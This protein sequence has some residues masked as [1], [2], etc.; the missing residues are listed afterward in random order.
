MSFEPSSC[1]GFVGHVFPVWPPE[2]VEVAEE[3]VEAVV[4][5]VPV[6]PE[7]WCPTCLARS[8]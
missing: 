4:I 7:V 2:V 6:K 1:F 5:L 3:G 8:A